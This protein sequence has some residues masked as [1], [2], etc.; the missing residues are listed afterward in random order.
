MHRKKIIIN[1]NLQNENEIKVGN[2]FVN[3]EVNS[4]MKGL[5]FAKYIC[6]GLY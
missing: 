3:F 5:N 4:T 2:T 1:N 6:I